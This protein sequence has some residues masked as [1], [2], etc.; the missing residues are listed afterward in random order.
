M[1]NGF[2]GFY[3]TP[4]LEATH[5]FYADILELPLALDQ[6]TCRIYAVPGGGYLGFCEHLAVCHTHK[7]PLITLITKEVDMVYERLCQ[8]GIKPEAP[9]QN[10]TR[11]NLYHFFVRDPAGYTV[12]IQQFLDDDWDGSQQ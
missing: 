12:E 1:W 7:S 9:P 11:F 10:N 4:N 8:A 5:S 2:I 6:G 3:G